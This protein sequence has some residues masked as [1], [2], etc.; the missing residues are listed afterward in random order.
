MGFAPGTAFGPQTIGA[1]PEPRA[2]PVVCEPGS[3]EASLAAHPAAKP[4]RM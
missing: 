3:G 2:Q 1:K 4:E